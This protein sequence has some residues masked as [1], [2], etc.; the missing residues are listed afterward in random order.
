[1]NLSVLISNPNAS[2]YGFLLF[3]SGFPL[4]Y[5]VKSSLKKTGV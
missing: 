3:I 1:V 2:L 5:L 4:F